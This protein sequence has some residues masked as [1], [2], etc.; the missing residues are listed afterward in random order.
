MEGPVSRH[1]A[2]R[3]SYDAVAGDYTECFR[4]EL[5]AK[6]LDRA[7]LAYLAEEALTALGPADGP[8]VRGMPDGTLLHL[9][10]TCPIQTTWAPQ[11]VGDELRQVRLGAQDARLAALRAGAEADAAERHGQHGK[12]SQQQALAVSY[13]AMHHAYAERK[14]LFADVMAN[15]QELDR[16]GRDPATRSVD[17]RPGRATPRI[18][19]PAGRPAQPDDPSRRPRLRRPNDLQWRGLLSGRAR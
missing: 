3:R 15:R 14:A 11:W 16:G 8:D 1:Y 5:A 19:L 18:R 12:A 9:R 6:P 10:V 4:D 13:R 7:L 17:H 2:V